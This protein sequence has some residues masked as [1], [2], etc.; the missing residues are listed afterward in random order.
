M[1]LGTDL[2]TSRLGLIFPSFS[3]HVGSL[4]TQTLALGPGPATPSSPVICPLLV[5]SDLEYLLYMASPPFPISV[6]S[7]LTP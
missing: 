5:R 4:L 3:S 1:Q 7:Y 2:K 6:M